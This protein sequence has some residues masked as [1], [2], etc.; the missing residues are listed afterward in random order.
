[1]QILSRYIQNSFLVFHFDSSGVIWEEEKKKYKALNVKMTELLEAAHQK[2]E[3]EIK[4]GHKP[5][6]IV[7]LDSKAE[8]LFRLGEGEFNA[9]NNYCSFREYL[10]VSRGDNWSKCSR[11]YTCQ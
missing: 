1:M 3:M 6:K 2:H 5:P 9:T 11:N 8:V 7:D 10:Y 4:L